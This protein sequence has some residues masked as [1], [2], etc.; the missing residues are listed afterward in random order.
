MKKNDE[1]LENETK[2]VTKEQNEITKLTETN[3]P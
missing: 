3:K 1:N 2:L